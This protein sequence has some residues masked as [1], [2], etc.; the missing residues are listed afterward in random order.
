MILRKCCSNNCDDKFSK[1][2][3]AKARNN[4]AMLYNINKSHL[5]DQ[6]T[7]EHCKGNLQ[8]HSLKPK[9]P[10]EELKFEIK[11]DRY[12]LHWDSKNIFKDEPDFCIDYNY[13]P[14]VA[15]IEVC[16]DTKA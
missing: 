5:D 12:Q 15:Y 2:R 6:K 8:R 9:C 10:G 14:D 13:R 11:N 3:A 7:R 1:A 4:F 16:F